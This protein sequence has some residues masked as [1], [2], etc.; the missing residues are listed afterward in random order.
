MISIEIKDKK[1]CENIK[2]MTHVKYYKVEKG[3]NVRIF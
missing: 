3:H 1:M 2:K